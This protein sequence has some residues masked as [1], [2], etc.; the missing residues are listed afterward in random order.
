MKQ[1]LS[2]VI[3][4][5]HSQLTLKDVV[6]D[7]FKTVEDDGRYDCEVILVNDNPPDETWQ[8]IES[9][10]AADHRVKGACMVHNF[11]QHAALMAGFGLIRG[12]IIVCLDDDGQTPPCEAFKLIDGLSDEVDAVYADYP[13]SKFSNVFRRLGSNL[14]DWMACWLLEKPKGLYLSSY[15]ATKRYVID[16]V[17]SYKGP[18]PYV[19]GLM[20]R[21][22]GKIINLP[23]EHRERTVGES[24]YS[25]KKLLGL[26]L[27][28]FT[29]FSIKPLR[30]GTA[31]G[32]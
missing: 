9:L 6:A 28:G 23:V 27:N 13:E 29:A 22:A 10:C 17:V 25:M 2:F 1:L 21:S 7:I 11:G 14:N 32:G 4:C 18:Y 26:W 31:L 24:G 30:L 20:L 3:P 5:Y 15:I 8:L 12:D 16:E 19:D